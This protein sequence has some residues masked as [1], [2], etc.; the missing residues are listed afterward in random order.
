MTPEDREENLPILGEDKGVPRS[1][2]FLMP[3]T[4]GAGRYWL[5][6]GLALLLVAV[7]TGLAAASGPGYPLD[8]SWIHQTYARNF[9]QSGRWEYV[10]GT[11]SAG[12][13]APLWTLLLALGYLLRLPH[14]L[15][16]ILLGGL[17]LVWIGWAGMFLW[18]IL[19]P[20]RR[21]RAWL[22]GAMLVLSWP[23]V[24]AAG[25]GMET[26]LFTALAL[27]LM[28]SYGNQLLSGR[29]RVA[30][31]GL[32]AGFLVLTR[33]DGLGLLLLVGLGVMAATGSARRRLWRLG[34][35]LIAA[36]LPLIPYFAFNL[37]SGGNLW[38]NTFYAKQVEYALL[39]DQPLPLRFL[40]LLYFSL[41]GPPQGLR[42]IS[43]AHLLLLP[44]LIAAVPEA[45]RQEISGRRLLHTLPLLW[46]VGH[47]LLYAWRLPVTYQHGRYLWPVLPVLM[48][49]GLAGWMYL[50]DLTVERMRSPKRFRPL[51]T[52]FAALT[53]AVLLLVF[54]LLGLQVY[55]QDIALINGEMV[56]TA[57]WL[58]ENTPS[59]SLIAAHD[60]GAIGYFSGRSLLDL[61]GLISPE[62]IP[63]LSNNAHMADYVIR[64]DT[65]FL[66]TAPGWPYEELVSR[67][68][69]TQVYTSG[70]AW[71][72]EQGL[73][74]TTVYRLGEDGQH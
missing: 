25:S 32:L 21:N 3:G 42:G 46:A 2:R 39:W 45:I 48:L 64:S 16:T 28:A 26:L 38:P 69:F 17:C 6:A 23:L 35:Y 71:T 52:K 20:A 19:W 70:F 57:L 72:R 34:A 49:Y 74:N 37:R 58:K 56:D 60:I 27:Q 9:A 12:S 15:W 24:W 66:I 7:Y 31:L 51:W 55:L 18:Q 41:G 61:A 33:P 65:D 54:L 13:T 5:V 1:F 63:L 50:T 44:G 47:I 59:D 43:G 29:W 73:N 40:Q 30:T 53:V 10:P 4:P 22:A 62:V 11:S 68:G 67:K 8:D 14:F 36:M